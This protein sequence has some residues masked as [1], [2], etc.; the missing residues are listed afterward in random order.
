MRNIEFYTGAPTDIT[1]WTPGD[2]TSMG[3][4]TLVM[5]STAGNGTNG[6][7]IS[8]TTVGAPVTDN[9]P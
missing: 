6:E 4:L 8:F 7:S 3:G 2:T 1:A 9:C 5:Q